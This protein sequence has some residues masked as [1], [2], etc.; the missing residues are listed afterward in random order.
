MVH[1]KEK[2][3][4][5]CVC[6]PKFSEVLIF[7]FSLQISLPFTSLDLSY[8]DTSLFPEHDLHFLSLVFLFIYQDSLAN[9]YSSHMYL[10]VSF[11]IHDLVQN[12]PL[13][14]SLYRSLLSNE[15]T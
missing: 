4:H 12:L 15:L 1:R 7:P 6:V 9:N 11:S 5:L 13:G 2:Q 10:Q 14:R 3:P 8:N